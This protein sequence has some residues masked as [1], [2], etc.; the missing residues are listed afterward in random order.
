MGKLIYSMMTSLDGFVE[1]PDR[2]LDWARIDKEIHE[3]ANAEFA[4]TG[5]SLH[6]RRIY[7]LMAQ[8][9][10]TADDDPDAPDYIVEFARIWRAKP[11]VVFSGTLTEVDWNTRLVDSDAVEEV[12]RLKAESDEDLDVAGP[13][14]AA[15]MIAAGLV[16]EYRLMVNPVILGAG[17][18]YLP[19]NAHAELVL[20]DVR[21][22]ESG[23]VFLR[24]KAG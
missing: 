15:S 16:D 4:S 23:V 8:F 9:W 10:P 5:I 3:F 1:T 19:A 24:Y 12:R 22:F 14:L 20:H 17:T 13:T 7:E 18:P 11:K 21:R 6:G 2:S